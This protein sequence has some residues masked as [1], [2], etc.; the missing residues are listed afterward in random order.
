VSRAASLQNAADLYQS[1]YID[2]GSAGLHDFLK[3]R[4]GNSQ[5]LA[6]TVAAH[7]RYYAAIRDSTLAIDRDPQIKQ[8]IRADF[9]HLKE[10]YPDAVFPDVYFLIGRMNSAGTTS[11][12]GLL[13]GVEMNARSDN[14]PLQ[15]LSPWERA[16]IGQIADLP[17]IVAHERRFRGRNDIGRNR[18][19]RSAGL[20][21]RAPASPVGGV[22]KTRDRPADLGYYIGYR[23]CDSFYRRAADRREALRRILNITDASEFLKE[24]GYSGAGP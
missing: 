5:S 6:A 7:A 16:V 20:R 23:I 14:T 10:L 8:S 4:I 12:A 22:P 15:E 1:E 24:S 13:I 18:Q 11:P 19:P 3:S 17:E 21:Q 2:P 9:V